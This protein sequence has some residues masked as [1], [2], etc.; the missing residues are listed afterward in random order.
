M[1]GIIYTNKSLRGDDMNK[2]FL[3]L[4]LVAVL[5]VG[6]FAMAGCQD[7]V[8]YNIDH[9]FVEATLEEVYNEGSHFWILKVYFDPAQVDVSTLNKVEI[10]AYV[11]VLN[12]TGN[13]K[14]TYKKTFKADTP[15]DVAPT[16]DKNYVEVTVSGKTYDLG[17]H[18][19]LVDCSAYEN[20]QVSGGD[21]DE[22]GPGTGVSSIPSIFNTIICGVVIIVVGLVAY[23]IALVLIQNEIVVAIVFIIPI[24]L[25]I[26]SYFAW[27]WVRG[28]ILTVC[29]GVY[30]FL[31]AMLNKRIGEEL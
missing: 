6:V 23:W 15:E 16:A 3:L 20:A 1:C 2:K 9:A 19:Y 14:G 30:Y 24:L 21:S 17:N 26:T 12:N 28:I 25:V 18:C 10:T 29:Y 8:K 4:C 11:T 5:V 13:E 27:G 7:Q 22:T 31:L